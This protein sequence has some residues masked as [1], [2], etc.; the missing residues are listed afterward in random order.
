MSDI[1]PIVIDGKTYKA[2]EEKTEDTCHGCVGHHDDDL[3]YALPTCKR[4]GG[5]MVIF[6]EVKHEA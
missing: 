2:V 6:V 5:D 1:T 4:T 3:C